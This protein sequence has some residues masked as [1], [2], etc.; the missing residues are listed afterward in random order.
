MDRKW[1]VSMATKVNLKKYIAIEG[2]WRFVSVLRIGGKPKTEMH[3][4]VSVEEARRQV[5]SIPDKSCIRA[6][7]DNWEESG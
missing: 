2:Q 3:L 5:A 4:R 7:D 1:I 6:A